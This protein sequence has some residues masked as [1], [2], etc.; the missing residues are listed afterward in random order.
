MPQAR[1]I[2]IDGA[3]QGSI[4]FPSAYIEGRAE[5][6]GGA[7]NNAADDDADDEYHA[8][9]KPALEI[10]LNT[11][12]PLVVQQLTLGKGRGQTF[13]AEQAS[14]QSMLQPPASGPLAPRLSLA[15]RLSP[16]SPLA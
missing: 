7:V 12:L 5:G 8:L 9:H 10:D 2:D 13:V 11:L 6:G 15:S 3:A 14:A 16:P 4:Q 1:L